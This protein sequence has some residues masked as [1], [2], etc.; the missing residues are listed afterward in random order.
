MTSSWP[1]VLCVFLVFD[2][3]LET[4]RP[5]A[6]PGTL[7]WTGLDPGWIP[8]GG[9]ESVLELGSR[10]DKAAKH[11]LEAKQTAYRAWF[12]E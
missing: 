7:D 12:W 10:P 5:T 3:T 2:T 8:A 4:D 1:G 6:L 11:E 9:L